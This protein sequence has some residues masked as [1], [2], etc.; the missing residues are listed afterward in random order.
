MAEQPTNKANHQNQIHKLIRLEQACIL[1][2]KVSNLILTQKDNQAKVKGTLA[3]ISLEMPYLIKVTFQASNVA[4]KKEGSET[5]CTEVSQT[6]L[7]KGLQEDPNQSTEAPKMK[8]LH[9]EKL[10]NSLMKKVGCPW[11]PLFKFLRSRCRTK[12]SHRRYRR[13]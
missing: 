2:C 8:D 7:D 11:M 3:K 6:T 4:V 5:T 9:L 13:K 10:R 12:N 1:R